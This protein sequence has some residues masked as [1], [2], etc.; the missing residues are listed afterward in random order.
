VKLNVTEVDAV[1]TDVRPVGADGLVSTETVL[2]EVDAP[3]E[4]VAVNDIE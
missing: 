3:D 2:D 4:F 1:L